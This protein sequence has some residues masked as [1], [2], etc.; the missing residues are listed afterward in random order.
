MASTDVSKY[1]FFFIFFILEDSRFMAYGMKQ[2]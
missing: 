2:S 1:I